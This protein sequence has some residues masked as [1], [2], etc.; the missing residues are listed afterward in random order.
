MPIVQA[1][2]D[3]SPQV[4]KQSTNNFSNINHDHTQ[5]PHA[6][7]PDQEQEV[8]ECLQKGFTLLNF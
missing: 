7:G 3:V 2:V 5:Q 1:I 8:K 4:L 6:T